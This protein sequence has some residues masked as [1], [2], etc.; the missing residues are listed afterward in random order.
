MPR[1]WDQFL[2]EQDRELARL[3]PIAERGLGQRPVLLMI[4]LYRNGFGDRPEP[5]LE[6]IETWPASCGTAGWEALPHIQK[7]LTAFRDRSLPVIYVTGLADVPSWRETRLTVGKTPRREDRERQYAIVDE[8]APR[9]DD[10]VLRKAAPSGFWGTILPG[11]LVQHQADSVVVVGQSTSGC[12]RAT[13]VDACANRYK[14]TVVENG[15]FDRTEA[16]HAINL[17]DMYQKYADVLTADEV[18]NR[19]AALG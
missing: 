17:F 18:V 6:A 16:S 2:T 10:V 9:E 8:V 13:V 7:V 1:I 14:V 19:V 4:D 5:L 11:L 12:V 3:H 15:V